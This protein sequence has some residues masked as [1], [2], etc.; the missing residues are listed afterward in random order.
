MS[1]KIRV[2][3]FTGVEARQYAVQLAELRIQVFAEWP[4][5]Y[6]GSL[7]YERKYIRTFLKARDSVLVLAFDGARV[8]GA[9]TGLPMLRET[10]NI[11]KPFRDMGADLSSIFYFS[12]SV[13][14]P[15]Y[16]GRGLGVAFFEQREE[17]ARSRG[18]RQAV[19][20]GVVRP[21]DHP[22]RPSDYVP[23]DAFWQKR[24][25]EKMEGIN[26][27][28]SWQDIDEPTETPKLLAFWGKKLEGGI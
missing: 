26:C 13:L 11:K 14:L 23:L 19:F 24:G 15:E 25:F 20:C 28:I 16:R 1:N 22:R 12:E 7:E 4:Y 6:L 3:S 9:S 2:E 27:S 10:P 21:P 18:Y 5:L 8:V 17:W